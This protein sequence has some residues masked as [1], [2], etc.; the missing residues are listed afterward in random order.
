MSQT[1]LNLVAISVF[2][3]TL[4]ILLG[5][6]LEISPVIGAIA[7]ASLLGF[8]TLDTLGWQG[9]GA[10][11]I[12]DTFA[13]LSGDH[14]SRVVRHEAGHFLVAYLLEI[15]IT[16]YALN[17][18]E[19]FKQGQS[20]G[21][22][23]QFDDQELLAELAQGRLSAQLFDRYCIIWMAGIAAETLTGDRAEGGAEDRTKLKAI[24]AQNRKSAT[25]AQLKER[26]AILQAKT[27][28]ESHLEAYHALV[29]AM[30]QRSPVSECYQIL[31][32]LIPLKAES[33]KFI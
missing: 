30:E 20:A 9:K 13:G 17:A 4:S 19:A 21:G 3:M 32:S 31:D 25:D 24:L 33:N 26:W 12:V 8:F 28:I 29:T 16:G 2:L 7:T 23:V 27:L 10:T 5:P 6:I 11:L 14:R 22:G 15:P 18:W 1:A